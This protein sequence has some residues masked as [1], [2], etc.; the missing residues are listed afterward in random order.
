MTNLENQKIKVGD[1]VEDKYN[2]YKVV[3]YASD[4]GCKLLVVKPIDNNRGYPRV[5][6]GMLASKVRKVVE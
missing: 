6:Y 4:S 5:Y 2:T 3:G 1:I